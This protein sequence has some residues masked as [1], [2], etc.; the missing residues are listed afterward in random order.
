MRERI[1][2]RDKGNF[3][4]GGKTN[5]INKVLPPM[6]KDDPYIDIWANPMTMRGVPK[7]VKQLQESCWT[8]KPL[9]IT[10][11]SNPFFTS[12][13]GNKSTVLP[14]DVFDVIADAEQTG[15]AIQRFKGTTQRFGISD[16]VDNRP[17]GGL[18]PSP[19]PRVSTIRK[20]SKFRFMKSLSSTIL[21]PINEPTQQNENDDGNNQSQTAYDSSDDD[22]RISRDRASMQ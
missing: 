22:E 12:T 6:T 20:T 18:V 13:G 15:G 11:I 5:L 16:N 1:V 10:A 8:R 2:A 3:L 9:F 19:P 17:H 7:S 21:P 14:N 4:A